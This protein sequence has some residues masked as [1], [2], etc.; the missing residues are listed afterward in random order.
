MSRLSSDIA[1]PPPPR[2]RVYLMRH[3]DVEYF[4]AAGASVTHHHQVHLTALGQEQCRSAAAFF[5][6]I[7]LDRVITSGLPRTMQTAEGVLAGRPVATSGDAR[8]REVEPGK[9]SDWVGVTPEKIRQVIVEGLAGT[10]GPDTPFLG[11]ETLG[12]AT[13]RALEAWSDALA[14]EGNTLLLVAHGFINR[15]ILSHCLGAPLTAIASM[16]QDTG[17]IN[18]IEVDSAGKY[19]VRLVNF[20]PHDPAKAQFRLSTLES[21]FQQFL[22]GKKSS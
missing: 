20:T 17:C 18:L 6:T 14:G 5:S 21:L 7:P 11:G 16:E 3:G 10:I 2:R 15:L 9:M 19:L 4:N 22:R 8:L 13:H 1:W 12:Q